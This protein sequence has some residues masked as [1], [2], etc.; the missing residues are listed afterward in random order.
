ML[1]DVAEIRDVRYI[2]HN[3]VHALQHFTGNGNPGGK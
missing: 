3:T 2:I 1:D